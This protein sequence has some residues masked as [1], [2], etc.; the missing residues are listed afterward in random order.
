MDFAE[1]ISH[2]NHFRASANSFLSQYDPLA[3]VFAPIVTLFFARVVHS[4][5]C[6]VIEK[7]LKSVTVEFVM[8]FVK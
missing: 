6:V 3:L 7:G 2:L 8:A 5:F 4:I 1:I